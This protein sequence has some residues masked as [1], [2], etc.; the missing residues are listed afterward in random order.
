MAAEEREVQEHRY[1]SLDRTI[2]RRGEREGK[3]DAQYFHVSLKSH[4]VQKP[5][6]NKIQDQHLAARLAALHQMG[7]AEPMGAEQWRVRR[8]FQTV[9]KTMQLTV[10]RQKML[11]AHGAL[12]SDERLRLSVVDFRHMKELQGRVLLHGEE[13]QGTAAGRHFLLLE[14][15]DAQIHLM[16]YTPEMEEARSR[17]NLKINHFA[18]LQK[19]FVNGQPLL[20]VDDFGDANELLKN[21]VF[22]NAS[23][24]RLLRRGIIP[25]EDGWNGWLGSY[26]KALSQAAAKAP[27]TM[28]NKDYLQ[29]R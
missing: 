24:Q 26:Q 25:S 10:D 4:P 3:G 8:D 15:T 1:T 6:W 7:L 23:A 5:A 13:E 18:R 29:E 21:N 11:A 2:K 22:L 17:G 9:L 27:Q 12:L 28:R 20:Q 16:F 14:G 19:Q